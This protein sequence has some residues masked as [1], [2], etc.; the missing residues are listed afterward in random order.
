MIASVFAFVVAG[1]T[2]QSDST[3]LIES[4]AAVAQGADI[5]QAWDI[6]HGARNL[7]VF[8]LSGQK[9]L[10]TL[11][12]SREQLRIR[13]PADPP[14]NSHETYS[15]QLSS[16]TSTKELSTEVSVRYATLTM[17]VNAQAGYA[18]TSSSVKDSLKLRR[19]L[20]IRYLPETL[21]LSEYRF[22]SQLLKE[23]RSNPATFRRHYGT[24]L[25]TAV[26]NGRH[27]QFDLEMRST[28]TSQLRQFFA[29]ASG[30]SGAFDA[31][32]AFSQAANE[33]STE[34]NLNYSK[35]LKG[36][37]LIDPPQEPTSASDRTRWTT[38]METLKN[39]AIAQ[40]KSNANGWPMVYAVV[41][42]TALLPSKERT[43][44][45]PNAEQAFEVFLKLE[46]E[47]IELNTMLA[48]DYSTNHLYWLQDFT[49][50]R[51]RR[52]E[53]SKKMNLV[54]K[55][56]AQAERNSK[57]FPLKAEEVLGWSRFS[58]MK[59]KLPLLHVPK[60][61]LSQGAPPGWYYV[62]GQ[63]DPVSGPRVDQITFS[64]R[65]GN[66]AGFLTG[67]SESWAE[68]NAFEKGGK[69]DTQNG[70]LAT[71][72][73]EGSKFVFAQL[74]IPSMYWGGNRPADQWVANGLDIRFLS[75]GRTVFTASYNNDGRLNGGRPEI[76][77]A[78]WDL[79]EPE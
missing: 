30:S 31:S 58:D 51:S 52:E 56:L 63:E 66:V 27:L 71:W 2:I 61:I 69:E 49:P 29:K 65:G 19:E 64:T 68:P 21:D 39:K 26:S 35:D 43:I 47:L 16:T 17:S 42:W 32:A 45:S 55:R 77:G 25:I 6:K 20:T 11:R 12:K 76:S 34:I 18:S 4:E 67:V 73:V 13:P 7:P 23:W 22:N 36:F 41:P 57:Q 75:R 3:L 5:G 9:R 78:A 59:V 70:F 38:Y 60:T 48:D 53:I 74:T 15:L 8:D 62:F 40:A 44:G 1:L 24:H 28:N 10:R 50:L 37:S 46:T 54:A 72:K 14:V 79:R 33:T